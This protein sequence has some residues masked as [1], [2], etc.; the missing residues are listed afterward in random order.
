MDNCTIASFPSKS[1][2]KQEAGAWIVK[3]DSSPLTPEQNQQLQQWMSTSDFHKQYLENLAK[4]WDAMAILQELADLFPLQSSATNSNPLAAANAQPWVQPVSLIARL[5]S[6]LNIT[7]ANTAV[8]A[9]QPDTTSP[10]P[11]T[12][13]ASGRAQQSPVQS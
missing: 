1:V 7:T 4:N 11:T 6:W 8:E 5:K 12:V 10:Q 2:I 3:I 9:A 13:P